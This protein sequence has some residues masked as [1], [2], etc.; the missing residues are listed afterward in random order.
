M[1]IAIEYDS[2]KSE[3]NILKRGFS[4]ELAAGFDF[5]TAIIKP[6]TRRDYGETRY[7]ATG[8]IGYRLYFWRSPYVA[9][10]CASSV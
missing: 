4:F 10:E 9:A 8:F 2:T 3:L 1:K 5:D 7:Q 6:D